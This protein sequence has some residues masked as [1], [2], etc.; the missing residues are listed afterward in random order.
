[1][2]QNYR[3]E[4][5]H[6]QNVDESHK[7]LIHIRRRH[8]ISSGSLQWGSVST[9]VSVGIGVWCPTKMM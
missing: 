4:S 1:M 7:V 3:G 6:A 9:A 2:I 8:D 5:D